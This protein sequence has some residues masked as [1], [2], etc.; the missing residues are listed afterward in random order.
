MWNVTAKGNACGLQVRLKMETHVELH[1]C[2][3][4]CTWNSSAGVLDQ[5]RHE[6]RTEAHG[7]DLLSTD[8][9]VSFACP[10]ST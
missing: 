6:S 10:G 9:S 2:G 8:F 5:S 3:I 4:K 1:A 7:A